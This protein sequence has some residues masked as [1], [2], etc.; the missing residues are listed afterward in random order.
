MSKKCSPRF[1]PFF[2][3]DFYNNRL[4]VPRIVKKQREEES[5]DID[6]LFVEDNPSDAELLL[7]A[8]R[9]TLPDLSI[10]RTFDGAETLQLI[11]QIGRNGGRYPKIILLD[12]RLPRIDGFEVLQHLR[13]NPETRDIQ[14]ITLPFSA[15]D[16]DIER[17]LRLGANGYIVKP[18]DY[19]EYIEIAKRIGGYCRSEEKSRTQTST[20]RRMPL[21]VQP[22]TGEASSGLLGLV[23]SLIPRSSFF[24]RIK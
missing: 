24:Q 15:S 12:L 6:I 1:L 7:R 10:H 19:R 2:R 3:L 14:V 16:P 11:E 4:D 18:M 8:M 23:Q 5:M 22:T 13:S 9:S 17:S 20:H 21:I